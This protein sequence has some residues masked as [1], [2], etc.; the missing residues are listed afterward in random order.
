M[1]AVAYK[2]NSRSSW[3]MIERT[4]IR[5]RLLINIRRQITAHCAN[6]D[7]SNAWWEQLGNL[8]ETERRLEEL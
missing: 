7:W 4:P 1:W 8:A 3:K 5:E 2:E 6:V